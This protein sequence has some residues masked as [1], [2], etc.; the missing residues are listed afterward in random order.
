MR[1]VATP[2]HLAA[3]ASVRDAL[4]RLDAT[5][6][7]RELGVSGDDPATARAVAAEADLEAFLAQGEEGSSL[8]ETLRS[9]DR[10]AD[11][12]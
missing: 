4:E 2:Q 7:A 1:A 5:R 6:E 9:L 10:L 8:E 12:V 3:A 11:T